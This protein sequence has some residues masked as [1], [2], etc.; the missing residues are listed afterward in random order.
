MLGFVALICGCSKQSPPV[1]KGAF[2]LEDVVQTSD[3]ELRVQVDR[4]EVPLDEMPVASVLA[5]LP[6]TGLADIAI[7]VTVPGAGGQHDYRKASG[8]I[9]FGCPTGC[10]IGDDV[11]RLVTSSLKRDGISFGHVTFDRADLR[12]R[13]DEGHV[14]V[15]RWHLESK[16][17]TL[18]VDLDIE[19]A[20]ELADSVVDGC[21]RFKASPSLEQRDPRT[22]AVLSTSGAPRGPDGFFSI[23]VGGNLG[24]RKLLGQACG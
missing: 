22:A 20:A 5:G 2:K 11:A 17:L 3:D 12:M 7:D 23:K 15:T 21:V 9:A 24:H 8:T 14:K 19:L 18:E 10:T 1:E 6:M 13:I 16:D 4:R